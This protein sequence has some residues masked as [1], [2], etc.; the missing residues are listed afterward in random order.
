VQDRPGVGVAV[1]IRNGAQVLLM[2]RKRS[3][4]SGTWAPP[5]GYLE[6]GERPED[7]AIREAKEETGIDIADVRFFAITND[8][9]PEGKH[10]ITLWFEAE[11][12]A[13]EPTVSEEASEVGWFPAANPPEPRFLPFQHLLSGE[14]YPRALPAPML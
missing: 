14:A 11:G 1:L 10:H 5:G 9:F 3:H 12:F 8:I 13:G 2:K 7:C 6:F 4:G